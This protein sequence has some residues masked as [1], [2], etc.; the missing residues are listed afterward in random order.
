MA[1][2]EI[3]GRW[4]SATPGKVNA[5]ELAPHCRYLY[6]DPSYEGKGKAWFYGPAHRNDANF[7]THAWNDM[8]RLLD[9][10]EAAEKLAGSDLIKNATSERETIEKLNA[11]IALASRK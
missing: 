8:I 5:E 2:E 1:F 7:F 3:R 9:I 4:E 11:S 10:A 6:F